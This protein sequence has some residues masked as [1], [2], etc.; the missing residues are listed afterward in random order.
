[1]SLGAMLTAN[2]VCGLSLVSLVS[3]KSPGSC[4]KNFKS[5]RWRLERSDTSY[6]H[7]IR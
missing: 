3:S 4:S 6:D 5:Q 7:R 1:M 2:C